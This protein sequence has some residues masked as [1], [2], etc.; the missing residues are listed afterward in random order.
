MPAARMPNAECLGLAMRERVD[1]LMQ[2]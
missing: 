2:P 1:Q